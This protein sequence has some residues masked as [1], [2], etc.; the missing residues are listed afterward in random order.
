V[1]APALTN[2][3]R[4]RINDLPDALDRAVARTDI[5]ADRTPLWWRAVGLLQWLFI[6]AAFGGLAW[7]IVGYLVR[8][9]GL[10]ELNNPKVG[11]VPMPTMLLLGGMFAGLL[12]WLLLKP[13]V[14]WGSRRA[15]RRAEQ[16]LRQSITEVSREY[17]VAPVR[18]VLNA[19]AQAR[20]ALTAVRSE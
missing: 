14:A 2:A 11:A 20:E 18:E 6:A 19:Y 12:L 13:A 10:P 7:L 9:L 4:S 17:V 5:G 15:H 8:A 1:W 3:S 16:R